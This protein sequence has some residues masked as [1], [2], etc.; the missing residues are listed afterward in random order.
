VPA[1][2]L[3][4][5]TVQSFGKGEPNT[6]FSGI[7]ELIAAQM[8][9]IALVI[10][11]ASILVPI[12]KLCVL[13]YLLISVQ[14]HSRQRLRDRTRLYRITEAIGRW[15]MVDI[16]VVAILVAL[17]RLG[18][19][20]EIE[21]GPAGIPFAGVVVLTMPAHQHFHLEQ[22][23]ADDQLRAA[24]ESIASELLGSG[25][26][27]QFRSADDSAPATPTEPERVPDPAE[28]DAGPSTPEDPTAMIIDMLGGKVVE[29]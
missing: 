9:P 17:V 24:L 13:C 11:I 1:N 27:L 16:Y 26:T 5:M 2:L 14:R 15:S 12:L 6:I 8:W 20:A 22:L 28:L 18:K 19:V 10:F 23:N 4:M 25:V 7:M 21:A 29:E 3:P